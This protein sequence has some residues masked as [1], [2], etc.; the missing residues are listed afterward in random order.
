MKLHRFFIEQPL[1]EEIEI[2]EKTLIHQWNNVLKFKINEDLIL[3]NSEKNT[4]N[5]D[6]IYNIKEIKKNNIIL[7]LKSKKENLNQEK[8]KGEFILCISLIKKDNLDLILQ[9]CTE[10]GVSK[11]IP[12]M[13]DR[14][15]KKNINSFNIER[16][17]KTIIEAVE[18]S[19]WGNI[20]ILQSPQDLDGILK[21]IEKDNDIENTLITDININSS[22]IENNYHNIKYLFVGPEG[23]WTE[24]ERTLFKKYNL[25][26]IS[27]GKNVLRAETA[28]IIGSFYILN[29]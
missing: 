22:K 12:I 4:I 27:F 29:Q 10:I 15:E 6:H 24:N 18:Q 16:S 1:G 19:G 14:V 5:T 25:K 20:P 26:T 13:S 3:F 2:K 11:F 21:L 9:K 28:A 17:K 8:G 7:Q 23:G